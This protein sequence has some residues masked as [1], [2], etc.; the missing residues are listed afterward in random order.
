VSLV[1]L[2]VQKLQHEVPLA[3]F[4]SQIYFIGTRLSRRKE[5]RKG[6]R[7]QTDHL[8]QNMHSL[9]LDSLLLLIYSGPPWA[10]D[11]MT[12]LQYIYH[13]TGEKLKYYSRHTI[14]CYHYCISGILWNVNN[15]QTDVLIT[16]WHLHH[17]M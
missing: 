13:F 11:F 5:G 16:I 6:G 17:N 2:L 15:I 9:V 8:K 14:Q 1:I 4:S 7:E 12:L 10:F 3:K